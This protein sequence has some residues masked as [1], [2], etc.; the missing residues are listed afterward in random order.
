MVRAVTNPPQAVGGA[1]KAAE[2]SPV[3]R[4]SQPPPVAHSFLSTL[5]E[6]RVMKIAPW[7]GFCILSVIMRE[8]GLA[9][10]N[11]GK[12]LVRTKMLILSSGTEIAYKLKRNYLKNLL[13]RATASD[14]KSS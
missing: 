12:S 9:N 8:M 3:E 14:F 6:R 2:V 13:I 1:G 4:S 10:I 11:F 5:F 7:G